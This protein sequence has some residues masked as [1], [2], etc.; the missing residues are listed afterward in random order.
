MEQSSDDRRWAARRKFWFPSGI[1]VDR[2]SGFDRRSGTER[3]TRPPAGL[4]ATPRSGKDRR[5][6]PERR[7][8]ERRQDVRRPSDRSPRK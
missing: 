4:Y 3:R 6:D 1:L 2:R 5:D 8:A 7:G